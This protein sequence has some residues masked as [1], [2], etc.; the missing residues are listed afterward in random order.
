MK[1]KSIMKH[2]GDSG[3][4]IHSSNGSVERFYGD[5]KTTGLNGLK[6][7]RINKHSYDNGF[8]I[9]SRNGKTESFHKSGSGDWHGSRGTVLEDRY[10]G[11]PFSSSGGSTAGGSA[12][13]AF[14]GGASI[15]ISFMIIV[16]SIV[17]LIQLGSSAIASLV[18]IAA[19]IFAR[20]WLNKKND[21]TFYTFWVFPF[22]LLGY[23]LL[24]N[25]MWAH[26]NANFMEPAGIVFILIGILG[27]VFIDNGENI[28]TGTYCI[29]TLFFMFVAKGYGENAPYILILLMLGVALCVT[30]IYLSKH[31]NE[32]G[33]PQ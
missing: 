17:A 30:P 24:V 33:K 23:R 8:D 6:G 11:I 26:T 19:T 22:T 31:K 10:G 21:T 14:W 27:S 3:I 25:A 12:S 7:T 20:A 1:I 9:V 29:V 28:V 15:W 18:M 32:G 5:Y 2:V 16:A 13:D 4:D